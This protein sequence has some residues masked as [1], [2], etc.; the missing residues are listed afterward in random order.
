MLIF[1]PQKRCISVISLHFM[2]CLMRFDPKRFQFNKRIGTD[3][4]IAFYDRKAIHLDALSMK[5]RCVDSK[6]IYRN[7]D[8]TVA[9]WAES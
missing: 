9:L 8:K 2:I 7:I 4:S 3:I 6:H 1:H 5:M